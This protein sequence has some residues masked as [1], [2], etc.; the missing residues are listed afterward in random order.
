MSSLLLVKRVRQIPGSCIPGGHSNTTRQHIL[1][2]LVPGSWIHQ[3]QDM[4]AVL[5][6]D[7]ICGYGTA[8]C[9]RKCKKL[10]YRIERCPNSYKCCLKKWSGELQKYHTGSNVNNSRAQRI[11]LPGPHNS[12]G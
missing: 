12:H 5:E 1:N 6:V 11:S 3:L 9:R 7:R 2:V 10:E 8:R 4:R